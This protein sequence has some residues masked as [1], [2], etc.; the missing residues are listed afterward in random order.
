MISL[1][2]V[3]EGDHQGEEQHHHHPLVGRRH[4]GM[5]VFAGEGAAVRVDEYGFLWITL[6]AGGA[7]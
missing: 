1:A 2:A 3:V 7:S 6:P 4:G 5:G